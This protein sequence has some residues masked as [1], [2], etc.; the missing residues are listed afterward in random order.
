MNKHC[1][2][3]V[4]AT[5]ITNEEWLEYRRQ[6]LGGS[7]ASIV[8]GINEYKSPYALWAEKAG[9]VESEFKGNKA[10]EWGHNLE[11]VVA[12]QYARETNSSVVCFPAILA[13]LDRTWQQANVDFFIMRH[14]YNNAYPAGYVTDVEASSL[15]F[16]RL[17]EPE[18]IL[19]IKT[20]GIASRG[21][22]KGWHY[23]QVPEA[24]ELQGRHYAS[25]T[26]ITKVVYACLVGGE[27][28]VIR[29]REYNQEQLDYLN[30]IEEEFW[31][32]VQSQTPP[33]MTGYDSDFTTLK[34]QFPTHEPDVVVET[35]EFGLDIY[36]E[37]LQA[38]AIADEAEAK[39][40]LIKAQ[41]E[42]MIGA[43]EAVAYDGR[44]LFTYKATAPGTT[45]D[46]KALMADHP[47]LAA[48]YTKPKPGYRVLRTKEEA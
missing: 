24:Y 18:A 22:A 1:K 44:T 5:E 35:D 48:K 32:G 47:E 21:N 15:W 31:N 23:G 6:G 37:F 10:T 8:A 9:I 4:N 42:L 39:V 28:L 30:R 36:K 40:K 17:P 34:A 7:D 13:S 27:G 25:V 41:L 46:T 43:A 11:R 12:E 33:D 2:V 19:E 26:G 20:T 16:S 45:I 3:V 38:K 14:D 29:E